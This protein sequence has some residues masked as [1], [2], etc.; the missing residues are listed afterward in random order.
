MRHG[1]HAT[2]HVRESLPVGGVSASCLRPAL[3]DGVELGLA[4][5]AGGAPLGRNPS[6]LLQADERGVDGALVQQDFVAADLLNAA[7][8]AVAVQRA[9]GGEGLQDHQVQRALQKI[10]FEG[11]DQ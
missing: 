6:A 10:Q 3:S 5:V 9:H 4:I 2:H 1:E 7:R 8:D 11:I